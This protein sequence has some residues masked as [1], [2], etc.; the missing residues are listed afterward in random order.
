MDKRTVWVL[1][2][3]ISGF[4]LSHQLGL[5]PVLQLQPQ[6]VG[7][8]RNSRVGAARPHAHRSGPP[9]AGHPH[10]GGVAG[11]G[12]PLGAH[13][14]AHGGAVEGGVGGQ[15]SVARLAPVVLAVEQRLHGARVRAQ[16]LV[17]VWERS[18]QEEGNTVRSAGLV[19]TSV[20]HT[21]PTALL[22]YRS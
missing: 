22:S 4:F 18:L 9:A 10:H 11:R 14:A 19:R 3:D 15:A 13:V 16:V 12:H 17:L 20:S 21:Q 5:Q 8:R 6:V 2:V 7:L 1:Q